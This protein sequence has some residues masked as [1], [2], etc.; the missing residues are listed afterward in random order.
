MTRLTTSNQSP[1]DRYRK[2]IE[3]RL[4]DP[5]VSTQE[6]LN[7]LSAEKG[8]SSSEKS[9]RRAKNRWGA[10]AAHPAPPKGKGNKP[11]EEKAG[12]RINGDDATVISEP[13]EDLK[14]SEE[15]VE[16]RGFSLDEW[17]IYDVLINEWDS[18]RPN[19]KGITKMRQ[20]KV[21]LRRIVPFEV[22]VP[23]RIPGKVFKQ[24]KAYVPHQDKSETWVFVGDQQAPYYDHKVHRIFQNFLHKVKPSQGILIGD[25]A[26]FP[27]IS[28]HPNNPEKDVSVQ[29][30]L[31]SAYLCLTEYKEANDKVIW[32]KLLGN[33]DERIRRYTIDNY[34]KAYGIRRAKL[35]DEVAE[36]PVVTVQHLMR[37]DELGISVID[38]EGDYE[39]GEIEVSPYL[40]ARHGWIARKGSGAS[41]LATLEHLGYSVI[42][43]HTH[44]QSLVH[45]TRHHMD[46]RV[47]TL[48]ACE[49][50]CMAEISGGLGYAVA[51]D[52]QNG[53]AV[54]EV[55]PSGKFRIDLATYVDGSVYFRNERYTDR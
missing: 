29:E 13:V 38:P 49:T 40:A 8:I 34:E 25:T 3:E 37:L 23:A 12:F 43:G 1:L 7:W 24:P 11:K 33:H 2:E 17:E 16:E 4:A 19:D 30:C 47:E 55:W 42:V 20:L 35:P 6:I 50:G 15:V 31:D 39:H 53:W 10:K 5:K 52:W 48:A 26:D 22:I 36:S 46:G 9:L 45:K 21:R 54:A 32:Q 28:R 18:M 51:P 14:S 27:S 41:A 44:R